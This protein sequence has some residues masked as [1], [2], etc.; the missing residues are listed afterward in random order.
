[1]LQ[2]EFRVAKEVGWEVVQVE[3]MVGRVM[4]VVR[5]VQEGGG[6]GL[7]GVVTAE[8]MVGR[9]MEARG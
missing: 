2:L 7:V 4:E 1:M 8:E 5:V 9:A 6:E 3:V